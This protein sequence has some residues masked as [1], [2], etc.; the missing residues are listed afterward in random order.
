MR[1]IHELGMGLVWVGDMGT[2]PPHVFGGGGQ[3]AFCPPHVL[4]ERFFYL[5]PR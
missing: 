5:V 4:Q 2:C 1:T 3:K